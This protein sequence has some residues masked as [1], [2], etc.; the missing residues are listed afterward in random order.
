MKENKEK[1]RKNGIGERGEKE[2]GGEEEL[3]R[4]GKN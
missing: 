1:G 2:E 4:Q 3:T